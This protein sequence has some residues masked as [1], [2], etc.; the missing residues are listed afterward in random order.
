MSFGD[1]ASAAATLIALVAL[2]ISILSYV[3]QRRLNKKQEELA[4]RQLAVEAL[5]EASR[6][7]ADIFARL[8]KVDQRTWRLK[9][10]NRGE[11]D[12]TNVR[13]LL[14]DE[15]RLVTDQFAS[16]KF[17]MQRMEP[18]QSVEVIA[19]V[20]LGGPSKETIGVAWDDASG[21]DHRKEIELTL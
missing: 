3:G 4:D 14:T 21:T 2:V 1:F 17:P 15:N 16:Q 7:Q 18:Q 19:I 5:N 20:V 8:C 10:F 11:A 12:A 9:V 13:L 6:K